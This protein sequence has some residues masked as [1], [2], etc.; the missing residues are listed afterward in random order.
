MLTVEQ[1]AKK[2]KLETQAAN[3]AKAMLDKIAAAKIK[4]MEMEAQLAAARVIAEKWGVLINPLQ[5]APEYVGVPGN[6]VKITIG[7]W[8]GVALSMQTGGIS[9]KTGSWYDPHNA[10]WVVWLE[11][12][13]AGY[14]PFGEFPQAVAAA[15]SARDALIRADYDR[16]RESGAV[17][18]DLAFDAFREAA[19]AARPKGRD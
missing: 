19:W 14:F 8:D 13:A 11:G 18:V 17:D 1:L 12:S 4:V 10:K 3:Q 7:L 16:A 6:Y 5:I 2:V 9:T 15:A